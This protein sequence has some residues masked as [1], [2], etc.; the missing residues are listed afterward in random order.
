MWS[1]YSDYT[2]NHCFKKVN[3][4]YFV[5]DRELN[6]F[7]INNK[8]LFDIKGNEIGKFNGVRDYLIRD[9]NDEKEIGMYKDGFYI[10]LNINEVN[11]N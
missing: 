5:L 10:Y 3:H 6:L 9:M 2:T 7:V 11:N 8:T 1:L 4:P